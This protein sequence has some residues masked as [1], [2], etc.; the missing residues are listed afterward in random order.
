MVAMTLNPTC[1]RTCLAVFLAHL[2]CF[3]L[4]VCIKCFKI[5]V[6]LMELANSEP[7]TWNNPQKSEVRR[8]ETTCKSIW[9]FCVFTPSSHL[10]SPHLFLQT[11][12]HLQERP[13]HLLQLC[14][15]LVPSI[16]IFIQSCTWG[17]VRFEEKKPSRKRKKQQL[18]HL[19]FWILGVS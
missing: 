8:C 6:I 3:R 14:Q 18:R 12:K 11:S 17:M 10:K 5:R 19:I 4:Q 1:L 9:I 7:G 15:Q 13:S 16:N 2:Q